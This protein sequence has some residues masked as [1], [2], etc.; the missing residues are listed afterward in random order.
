MGSVRGRMD[1]L[2]RRAQA[3]SFQRKLESSDFRCMNKT[4]GDQPFGC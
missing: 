1:E 4:L 2:Q 3:P